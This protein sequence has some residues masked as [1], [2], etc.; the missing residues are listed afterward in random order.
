M[1]FEKKGDFYLIQIFDQ[2]D[3]KEVIAEGTVPINAT[4]E[5]LTRFFWKAKEFLPK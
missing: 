2:S 3:P 1:E 5:D 4:K